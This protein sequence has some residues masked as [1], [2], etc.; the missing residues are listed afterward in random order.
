ML[1]DPVDAVPPVAQD[2]GD[3]AAGIRIDEEGD[4]HDEDLLPQHAA[5]GLEEQEH[6]GGAQPQ[7]PAV[8]H[9]VAQ[10]QS[11]EVVE[12]VPDGQDGGARQDPVERRRLRAM[13]AARRR[14]QEERQHHDAS[15]VEGALLQRLERSRARRV[16]LEKGEADGHPG[17]DRPGS[18]GQFPEPR[19]AVVLRDHLGDALLYRHSFQCLS[20]PRSK[21]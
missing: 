5:R 20:G 21:S 10:H 3:P 19:F 17:G 8:D 6:P 18:A 7:L 15:E 13:G 14:V 12:E 1:D 16:E 9:P 4:R 11:L 2:A